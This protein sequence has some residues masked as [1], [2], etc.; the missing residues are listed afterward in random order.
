L[1]EYVHYTGNRLALLKIRK[2][3]I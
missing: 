1:I 2:R 3:A